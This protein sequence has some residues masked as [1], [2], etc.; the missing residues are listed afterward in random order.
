VGQVLPKC[1]QRL[2][3]FKCSCGSDVD[4][5]D[6]HHNDGNESERIVG[7]SQARMNLEMSVK[8]TDRAEALT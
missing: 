1:R 8:S 4:Q 3:G 5:L 6:E 2:D 7:D